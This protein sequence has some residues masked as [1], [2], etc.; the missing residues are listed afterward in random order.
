MAVELKV[1]EVGESITE[2]QIGEWLKK[3]GE[4]VKRD[5]PV[6]MIETDKVTVELPSPV[7][8]V[9]TEIKLT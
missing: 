4:A 1:P 2:V 5:E 8:G 6:V 3:V 9:I 7:D